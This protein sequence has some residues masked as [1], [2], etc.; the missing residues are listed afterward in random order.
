MPHFNNQGPKIISEAM[1]DRYKKLA[2]P[3]NK[4][5]NFDQMFKYWTDEGNPDALRILTLRDLLRQ[6]GVHRMAEHSSNCDDVVYRYT[7]SDYKQIVYL[8]DSKALPAAFAGRPKLVNEF[9]K[10]LLYN[11][12]HR[13]VP[14]MRLPLAP[15]AGD[16]CD[17]MIELL[18]PRTSQKMAVKLWK[19]HTCSQESSPALNEEKLHYI[20]ENLLAN[21]SLPQWLTEKLW[22][23]LSNNAMAEAKKLPRSDEYRFFDEYTGEFCSDEYMTLIVMI[24]KL[25]DYGD[26][27]KRLNTVVKLVKMLENCFPERYAYVP[28]SE[29]MQ[30]APTLPEPALAGRFLARHIYALISDNISKNSSEKAHDARNFLYW[31]DG[32]FR[33]NDLESR[34]HYEG[35]ANSIHALLNQVKSSDYLPVY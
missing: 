16:A 23:T 5:W 2:P 8:D 28:F 29:V 19:Y 13:L 12:E 4:R 17:K 31:A 15:D 22:R 35:Y 10:E 21:R 3:S 9:A 14:R 25:R 27:S 32:F 30:I 24:R 33:N 34:W 20:F 6:D 26:E 7:S 11:L 1:F 18:M